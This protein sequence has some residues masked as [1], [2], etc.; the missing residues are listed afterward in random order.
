M[1][2]FYR[3]TIPIIVLLSL[4]FGE[5]WGGVAFGQLLDSAALF[6]APVY[7]NLEDALKNPNSV[8]RLSLRGKKLKT[9]P[10][11]ILKL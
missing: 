9:F 7:D 5:G 11:D 2:L 4:P 10:E 1:Q 8:Y 3:I 6:S